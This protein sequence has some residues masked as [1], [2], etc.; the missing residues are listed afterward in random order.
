MKKYAVALAFLLVVS[1][2]GGSSDTATPAT[3]AT[4]TAV[5]TTTIQADS[6]APATTTDA[7]TTTSASQAGLTAA[8]TFDESV[9]KISCHAVGFLQGS[10]LRWESNVYGWQTVDRY[11]R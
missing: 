5:P 1:G 3:T 11:L 8:C 6:T 9:P 4:T 7:P 2:C 10:Q